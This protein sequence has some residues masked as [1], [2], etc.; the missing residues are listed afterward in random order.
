ME[1]LNILALGDSHFQT[2][3]IQDVD[4]YLSKLKTFLDEN[5]DKI[6]LIISMGDVLHDH[7]RLH[8]TP[9]NK[10]IEYFKLLSS[11]KFTYC[12]IGNHDMLSENV[13]LT[14]DHWLNCVKGYPN[15]EV[16]DKVLLRE[17]KGYK[18]VLSCYVK[19]GRFIEA[20]NTL[21]NWQEANAIFGHITIKGAKMGSIICKDADYWDPSFPMLISGHIH[22]SQW[23]AENMYYTGSIFQVAIDEDPKKHIVMVKIKDKVNIQEIDL[24]LPKKVRIYLDISEIEEFE[25]PK[26]SNTKYVLIIDG[27]YEKFKLFKKS[28]LYKSLCK[29]PYILNGSKG[30]QFRTVSTI[31][32]TSIIPREEFKSFND[33][34]SETLK[35]E[36]ILFD[37]YNSI[38]AEE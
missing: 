17:H 28:D 1:E 29:S 5:K 27:N 18:I 37:L 9:L 13:F 36:T 30:I 16:V 15:L 2:N 8:V 12:I 21:E 24:H 26:E 3:N 33:L 31:E 23:L 20:L 14:P 11:Y 35:N 4:I 22:K 10:A 25:F 19:D 34:L 6:D 38:L 32:N 7:S